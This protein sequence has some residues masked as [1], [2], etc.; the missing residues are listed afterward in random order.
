MASVRV[1]RLSAG[2]GVLFLAVLLIAVGG[3][4]NTIYNG[5][6]FEVMWRAGRALWSGEPVY[7][8]ARDGAMVFKY[9]PWIAP[10]FAPWALLPL[11]WAK[12][13]WGV[14]EVVSAAVVALWSH[15]QGAGWVGIASAL[16]VWWGSWMAHTLDGQIALTMLALA[17]VARRSPVMIA[18]SLSTKAHS[19][20]PWLW[21]HSPGRAVWGVAKVALLFL[22]LSLPAAFVQEK[23]A[24][25]RVFPAWVE[26]AGSGAAGF[27]EEK[28]RG[29]EN[30]GFAPVGARVL[31]LPARGGFA[32]AGLAL[33]FGLIL[34][35]G[36]VRLSRHLPAA[37]R[38][39]GLLALVP[40]YHPLP[41]NHLF[42]FAWPVFA[43]ALTNAF[44]KRAALK[45]RALVAGA[46]FLVLASSNKLFGAWGEAFALS[47][48]K[49]FAVLLILWAL[50]CE[51]RG[52]A[53][54]PLPARR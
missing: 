37:W 30:S 2:H 25:W 43:L 17:L 29:H 9:P 10:F 18:L 52:K 21:S 19:A 35:A 26:S 36:W 45:P 38:W 20:L 31:G 53:I 39:A 49:S 8:V 12:G 48:A 47:A 50:L 32:E 27:S 6:D 42:L 28:V 51:I 15:R 23:S 40:T 13:L 4:R 14:L 33:F 24:P 1:Q 5:H 11:S 22:L 7:S 41:W 16:L 34:S 54:Q 46:V 3:V 44:A